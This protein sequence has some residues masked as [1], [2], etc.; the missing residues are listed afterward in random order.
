MA[1]ECSSLLSA[2]FKRRRAEIKAHKKSKKL[3]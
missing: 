3:E 1:E 2:F